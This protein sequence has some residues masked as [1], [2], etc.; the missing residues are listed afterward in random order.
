MII[1]KH[2]SEI[3]N[4]LQDASSKSFK[5]LKILQTKNINAV[6]FSKYKII[7]VELVNSINT[8]NSLMAANGLCINSDNG[9]FTI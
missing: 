1:K 8:K 2:K 5:S 4:Y 7:Q 9:D 3:E 6:Y